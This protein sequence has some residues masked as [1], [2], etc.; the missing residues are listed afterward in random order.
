MIEMY[1]KQLGVNAHDGHPVVLL[2]EKNGTR[3]IPIWVGPAEF[4]AI[5]MAVNKVRPSR[6]MTHDLMGS[7]ITAAGRQIS[8]LDITEIA[9]A[10]FLAKLHLSGKRRKDAVLDCRPSDGIVLALRN[11]API[12]VAPAVMEVAGYPEHERKSEDEAFSKFLENLKASD[13]TQEVKSKSQG[14]DLPAGCP[15]VEVAGESAPDTW[16]RPLMGPA[17]PASELTS[18]SLSQTS[19]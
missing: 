11:G 9:D 17:K 18:L 4:Q 15:D 2:K 13:F 5:A 19:I 1:V 3:T 8:R 6:P 12:M 14:E 7:I 16:T 10:T